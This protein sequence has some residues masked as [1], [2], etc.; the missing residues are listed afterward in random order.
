MYF[1]N[2][3]GLL[4]LLSLPVI[5]A[6]HLYQRRFP[7]LLVAGR[8][9]VGSG[10]ADSDCRPQARPVADHAFAAAR[11]AG[12]TD[13]QSRLGSAPIR[14]DGQRRT[15]GGRARRLGFDVR[16]DRL[17]SRAFASRRIAV[18][19]ERMDDLGRDARITLIRSG[20]QPTLLGQQAMSW[21]E[22]EVVLTDW[23]PR[24]NEA[25]LQPRLGRGRPHRRRR[26]RVPVSHRPDRRTRR[27]RCRSAWRSS[28]S[29][30]N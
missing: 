29:V 18:L 1:A 11:T 14:R 28:R 6:I 3:W 12:R 21:N 16:A 22:A 17:K 5:T 19:G 2:P 13:L 15:S 7:P 24:C 27:Q 23:H 26:R 4:G 25:R 8:P 9:F 30:A 20:L 10:D